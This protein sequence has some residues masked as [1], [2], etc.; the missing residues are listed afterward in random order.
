MHTHTHPK[1]RTQYPDRV[2]WPAKL[3]KCP[4]AAVVS[5]RKIAGHKRNSGAQGLGQ[6]RTCALIDAR[7]GAELCSRT[8]V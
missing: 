7:H 8:F 3:F 2:C 4:A 5:S 1:I 6:A